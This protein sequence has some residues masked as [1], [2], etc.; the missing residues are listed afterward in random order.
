MA[1]RPRDGLTRIEAAILD[2]MRDPTE[3]QLE[4]ANML[5]FTIGELLER[6]GETIG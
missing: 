5:T 2:G 3:R 4:P 1:R 6:A